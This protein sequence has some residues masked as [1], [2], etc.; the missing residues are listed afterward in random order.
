VVATKGGHPDAG[1]RYPRPDR[2]LSPELLAA[3]ITDSLRSLAI[4]TIDLYYLHRDDPRVPVGEIIDALNREIESGRLRALGASNWSV[5]RI[6]AANDWASQHGRAGFVASQPQW[7]LGIPNWRPGPEPS[8]RFVTAEDAAWYSD[9]EIAVIPY[10]ST[11]NGYFATDGNRG[12]DYHNETNQSRLHRAKRL[13]SER[14][15][16]PGQ[17]ALAYLMNQHPMVIPI[18]GTTDEAHLRDA[19][20]ASRLS[21]TPDELHWLRDGD[22][23][24]LPDER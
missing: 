2:Y 14:A 18:I 10:S 21:L 20:G 15:C 3:D 17:I 7:S 24:P 13:A 8:M 5:A 22:P 12:S 23:T 11:S 1:P 19:L 6:E 16:T 4:D 9:H